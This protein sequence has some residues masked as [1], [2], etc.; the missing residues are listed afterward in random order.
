MDEPDQSDRHCQPR[1]LTPITLTE[2][3]SQERSP[4]DAEQ[5]EASEHVNRQVEGVIPLHLPS[6]QRVVD[7]EGKARDRTPGHRAL[8]ARLP[9]PGW[10]QLSDVGIVADG[11]MVVE[12]ERAAKAVLVGGQADGNQ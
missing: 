11:G 6:P 12:E 3:F 8:A 1:S 2:T 4:H 5:N 10:P 9:G 7:R